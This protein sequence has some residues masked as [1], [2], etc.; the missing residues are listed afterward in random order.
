MHANPGPATCSTSSADDLSCVIGATDGVTYTYTVVANSPAGPSAESAASQ[1]MVAS[2]PLVPASAPTSAPT[3]LTTT[4]GV[5]TQVH[6]GQQIT[7]L[8]EGFLPYS[9]VT[10][11][12]YSSPVV[13]GTAVADGAGA[14]VRKVSIPADLEPGSHNLVASGV[15]L[16]GATHL[17]RMPVTAK[18]ASSGGSAGSG[19]A[20]SGDGSAGGSLPNT[21]VQ[22]ARLVIWTGLTTGAGLMLIAS[23]RRRRLTP[24][25]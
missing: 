9:S 11:I 23:G 25:E 7:I 2:A 12:L 19:G 20:G 21:G 13:L 17:I 10:I 5:L 18:A 22:L 3:T 6:P 14:F 1:E 24:S 16:A 15:D 4:D 8:G